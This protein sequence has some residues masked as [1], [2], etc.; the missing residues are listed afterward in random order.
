MSSYVYRDEGTDK[1]WFHK[2]TK[3]GH[4]LVAHIT[5]STLVDD[6]DD[7]ADA[8]ET[9]NIGWHVQDSANG[10]VFFVAADS[11]THGE[12]ENYVENLTKGGFRVKLVRPK[13]F[14]QFLEDKRKDLDP[15][16]YLAASQGV[17]TS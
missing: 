2:I 15:F 5:E 12:G 16:F 1:R 17:P 7:D 13:D 3:L 6:D 9:R 10:A 8:P 14:H 11:C 4:V